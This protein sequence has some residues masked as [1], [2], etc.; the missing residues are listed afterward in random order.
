MPD[1]MVEITYYTDP[2][3]CWS[4]AM[5]PAWQRLRNEYPDDITVLYKMGGLLPSWTMYNDQTNSIRK[6]VQMGPEWMHARALTGVPIDDRIWVS[7]PPASSFPA[8][9]AVKT[10]ELQGA[11]YGE[12]YLAIARRAVMT[13]NKNIARAE[14]LLDLASDLA[15]TD[16][17][18]DAV[19]FRRDL[20]GRGL[21][22]FREDWKD[23]KYQGIGRFPTLVFRY[24]DRPAIV[25]RGYQ[26]YA[27]LKNMV[28]GDGMPVIR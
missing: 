3:C 5:E 4:W 23:V 16:G 12:R 14:V 15:Q 10:A 19:L 26:D 6:P 20:M 8:C 7:D 17:G 11:L 1:P 18:F 27:T 21:A 2:L 24:T 22:A 13:E 25:L 9:I 28:T